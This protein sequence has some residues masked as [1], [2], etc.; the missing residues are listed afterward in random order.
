MYEFNLADHRAGFYKRS[1]LPLQASKT[2]KLYSIFYIGFVLWLI[3]IFMTGDI[4]TIAYYE[5]PMVLS[6]DIFCFKLGYQN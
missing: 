5:A 6:Y 3:C 1:A 2:R 4:P